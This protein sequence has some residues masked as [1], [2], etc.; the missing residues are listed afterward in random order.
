[1]ALPNLTDEDRRSAL[2][3][4]GEARRARAD[5]KDGLRRGYLTLT[6]VIRLADTSDTIGRMK[7]TALLES[8]P[9]VGKV[10]ARQIMA[11]I[12]IAESRRVRGLGEHQR[13]ALELEFP[14]ALA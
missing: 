9:G 7:V 6:E 3:K 14:A 11:S 13:A 10:R 12:G 5:I 4:A 1:M 8:L 2:V